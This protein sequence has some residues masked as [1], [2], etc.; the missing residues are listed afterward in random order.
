MGSAAVGESIMN[1]VEK[2]DALKQCRALGGRN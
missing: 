2:D 1:V